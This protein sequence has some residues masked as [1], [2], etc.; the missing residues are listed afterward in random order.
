MPDWVD[1]PVLSSTVAQRSDQAG[2][3]LSGGGIEDSSNNID[4]RISDFML[5]GVFNGAFARG[6]N[7]PN[8]NIGQENPLPDW[9]G[10]TQV[11]GG[12]ITCSHVDDASSPSGKNLRFTIN[13]GAAADEAYVEQIVPVGGSRSRW[14]A[15]SIKVSFYRVSA[16]GGTPLGVIAFQYLT[17]DGTTTGAAQSN[18]ASLLV[19]ATL[20][21]SLA[22]G[23]LTPPADAAFLRIR[24]GVRRN[25]MAATDTA[26]VDVTD[27][28][29]DRG[30]AYVYIGEYLDPA[31]YSPGT[32]RQGS[33][34]IYIAPAGSTATYVQLD[35]GTGYITSYANSTFEFKPGGAGVLAASLTASALTAA[36]AAIFSGGFRGTVIRPTIAGTVDNWNP[37]GLVPGVT[38]IADLGGANR[39]ITGMAAQ[40]DGALV[41]LMAQSSTN[42]ITL[43][44][45][46]ASSSA[47]N[48]F[49]A[50]A[51][52]AYVVGN[53]A[54][55][56]LV[57]DA[58]DQKWRVVGP[59]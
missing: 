58:T 21:G 44:H 50:P 52:V 56:T 34:A 47:A 4:P 40:A 51:G 41:Y 57:Y 27:V 14:W 15:S 59:A 39:I 11:S 46:S 24:V 48:Q 31:T 26:I 12:A 16:S 22:G 33:G 23:A 36:V 19:D 45:L 5:Y 6:P 28:R 10:P 3:S 18:T 7:D 1:L 49:R 29:Q 54:G 43:N 55:V 42:T 30:G 9:S 13:K 2:N 8:I 17:A 35:S 37:T 20:Y 25:T 32:I 38:I 53:K